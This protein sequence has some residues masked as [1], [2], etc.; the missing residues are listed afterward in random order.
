MKH[1][2]F[3][4]L[5]ILKEYQY[6]WKTCDQLYSS[7][8]SMTLQAFLNICPILQ[9]F[10]LREEHFSSHW[11]CLHMMLC[12][13]SNVLQQYSIRRHLHMTSSYLTIV[14]HS[15]IIE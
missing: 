7:M 11:A 6:Y 3:S 9:D 12:H 14:M 4:K 5:T 2:N 8:K 13:H 10:F 15:L 1:F